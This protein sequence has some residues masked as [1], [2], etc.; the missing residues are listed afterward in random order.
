MLERRRGRG[1]FARKLPVIEFDG[2]T[3]ND[4]SI[5]LSQYVVIAKSTHARLYLNPDIHADIAH[6]NTQAMADAHRKRTVLAI[7][8]Q[9]DD[10]LLY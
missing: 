8:K 6:T 4:F 10:R 5:C 3:R 9:L 1:V 2:C 7:L